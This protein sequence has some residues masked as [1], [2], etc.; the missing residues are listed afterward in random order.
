MQALCCNHALLWRLSLSTEQG[1]I[2][3]MSKGKDPQSS[4][5]QELHEIIEDLKLLCNANGLPARR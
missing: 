4:F 5:L 2:Q 3:K 1:Y